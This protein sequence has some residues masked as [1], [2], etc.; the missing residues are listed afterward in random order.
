[1]TEFFTHLWASLPDTLKQN[2]FFQGGAVLGLI[3]W[4]GY[5]LRGWS[6]FAWS[7]FKQQFILE[8]V[9]TNEDVMFDWLK[10][11]IDSQ[12]SMNRVRSVEVSLKTSQNSSP[13]AV[14]PP[15]G[16]CSRGPAADKEDDRPQFIVTPGLGTHLLWF[17]KRL[18]WFTRSRADSPA[19]GGSSSF[20]NLKS[21]ETISLRF[22]T[23][24]RGLVARLFNEVRDFNV[25]PTEPR[26]NIYSRNYNGWRCNSSRLRKEPRNVILPDGMMEDLERDVVEFRASQEWYEGKGIPWRRGF[27][28]KG[29]PGSGKT[30]AAIELA[31]RTGQHLGVLPLSSESFGDQ[32]LV[33]ALANLPQNCIV[34]FEDIDCLFRKR[35]SDKDNAVLNGTKVTF[36]GFLNAID[37]AMSSEGTMIIVST[38]HPEILDAA[39][40][41]PGRIDRQIAFDYAD[42][43]QKQRMF[44][45]FYP[46]TNGMSEHFANALA[47]R[48]I[49][50]CRLQEHLVARR[51]VPQQALD[52]AHL[53]E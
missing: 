12:P 10:A 5:N 4:I 22:F 23:R 1:M 27:L 20:M 16:D 9:V 40:L 31:R 44:A 38:N 32:D 39:L 28:F 11:W 30:S 41:R 45:H 3:S 6:Q 29:P 42:M 19:G 33:Q 48:Q 53:L 8:I 43:M 36:S 37:G 18:V 17:H 15:G 14:A 34:L 21:K 24:D 2:Q 26:M 25:P 13:Q 49:S 7:R 35:E 52:E 51:D 46:G 47:G 50:M